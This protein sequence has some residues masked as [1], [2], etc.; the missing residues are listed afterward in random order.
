M[1][2]KEEM[3]SNIDKLKILGKMYHLSL[4]VC[5]YVEKF[6]RAYKFTLGD[7]L[8]TASDRAEE[9]VLAVW[10]DCISFSPD[11]TKAVAAP[12]CCSLGRARRRAGRG[13]R[14]DLLFLKTNML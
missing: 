8:V 12:R 14:E 2:S 10:S 1:K 13:H 6:N 7:R 5:G 9:E 4:L 3:P 11:Y